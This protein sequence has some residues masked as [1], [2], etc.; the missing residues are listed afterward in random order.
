MVTTADAVIIGAG[1]VGSST[2]LELSRRGVNVLVVDKAGG[3]GMGSTSASSAVVRFNYSTWEGVAASEAA[4]IYVRHEVVHNR[5]VVDDLKAKGAI[6]IE[7]LQDVPPGSTLFFFGK[8]V[9]PPYCR[10]TPVG[11][12]SKSFTKAMKISCELRLYRS[13]SRYRHYRIPRIDEM[14]RIFA[15]NFWVGVGLKVGWGS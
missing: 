14:S 10:C 5:F 15:R 13:D 1:V 4:P 3:A 2:A 12:F 11:C 6:F 9:M 7:S 8:F